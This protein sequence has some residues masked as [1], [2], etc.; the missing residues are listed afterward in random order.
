MHSVRDLRY[1]PIP[2]FI[3]PVAWMPCGNPLLNID[4]FKINPACPDVNRP[5]FPDA[6]CSCKRRLKGKPGDVCISGNLS[7]EIIIV[8]QKTWSLLCE[9]P[10]IPVDLRN[11]N[12]R[13]V[14]IRRSNEHIKIFDFGW[15][16]NLP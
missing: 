1:I 10:M 4:I 13:Q 7:G 15:I 16:V 3:V 9:R 11:H 12:N 2:D 6:F 8:D 5:S 14:A